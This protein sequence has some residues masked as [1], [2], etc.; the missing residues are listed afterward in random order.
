MLREHQE[1][2]GGP[3]RASEVEL[4]RKE[5]SEVKLSASNER[6]NAIRFG[7]ELVRM[8]SMLSFAEHEKECLEMEY[9]M[10]QVWNGSCV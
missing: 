3:T 10:A 8:Q 1:S 5:L 4:L 9:E 2:E 7:E 6:I